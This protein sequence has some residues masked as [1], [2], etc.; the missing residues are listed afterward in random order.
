M[1]RWIRY[2]L[3]WPM[4]RLVGSHQY[5][6]NFAQSPR[7]LWPTRTLFLE[8]NCSSRTLCSTWLWNYWCKYLQIKDIDTSS[9]KSFI[10]R[11]AFRMP[12]SRSYPRHL[13]QFCE[14]KKKESI[15]P[16]FLK[17]GF[18]RVTKGNHK[19]PQDTTASSF[20]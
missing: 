14:K 10:F 9:S 4:S 11:S 16:P 15:L 5:E 17:Q 7:Y 6:I 19:L 18:P 1:G 13:V 20:D 8:Y 12:N 3:P 2:C